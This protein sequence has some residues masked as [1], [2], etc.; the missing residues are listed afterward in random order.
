M[1]VKDFE[2]LQNEYFENKIDDSVIV[3]YVTQPMFQSLMLTKK[4]LRKNGLTKNTAV[5]PNV[6]KIKVNGQLI[7]EHLSYNC[8][9]NGSEAEGETYVAKVKRKYTLHGR[10]I[11]NKK[12]H[13][14]QTYRTLTKKSKVSKVICPNCGYEGTVESFADGCDACGSKFMIKDI[15]KKYSQYSL[16]QNAYSQQYSG[17]SGLFGEFFLLMFLVILISDLTRKISSNNPLFITLADK[18]ERN[19]GSGIIMCWVGMFAIIFT[20]GRIMD[21]TF[22]KYKNNIL[23]IDLLNRVDR[24]ISPEELWQNIDYKLKGIHF[25]EHSSEINAF[26]ENIM[27]SYLS[28]YENVVDCNLVEIELMDAQTD[29]D[30]YYIKLKARVRLYK[31]VKSKIKVSYES[32]ILTLHGKKKVI[33]PRFLP[34]HHYGCNGCGASLDILGGKS[35]PQCGREYNYLEYDWAIDEYIAKKSSNAFNMYTK[36]IIAIVYALLVFMPIILM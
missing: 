28:K 35:C 4:R 23:N 34:I 11:Y 13:E 25:A 22:K 15:G 32:V 36:K 31:F 21:F 27:D 29:N 5:N 8:S 33:G 18:F 30:D 16:E 10:L 12:T 2:K 24:C 19:I 14:A 1:D 26:S 17:M 7:E 20:L 9:Y 6:T 3:D